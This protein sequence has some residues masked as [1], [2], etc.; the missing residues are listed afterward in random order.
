MRGV[1]LYA[2]PLLNRQMLIF[3][4]FNLLLQISVTA[5]TESNLLLP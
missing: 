5:E 1:A 2:T 4:T 3:F